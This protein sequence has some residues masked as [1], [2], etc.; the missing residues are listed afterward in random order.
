MFTIHGHRLILIALIAF[1]V[2][3]V[4]SLYFLSTPKRADINQKPAQIY[5]YYYIYA[6]E[7]GRELMRVPLAIS[8]DDELIT[9]DNKRYKVIKVDGDKGIARFLE[10]VD[11]ERYKPK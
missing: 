7:D 3:I 6:E 4:I 9:E 1:A 2:G 5:E 8:V 11:I 10:D